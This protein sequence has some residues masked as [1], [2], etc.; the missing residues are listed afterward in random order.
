VQK[1][2]SSN[3]CGEL[4]GGRCRGAGGANVAFCGGKLILSAAIGLDTRKRGIVALYRV[5]LLMR[6]AEPQR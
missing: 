1:A 5:Y 3:A 6:T 2:D 4:S